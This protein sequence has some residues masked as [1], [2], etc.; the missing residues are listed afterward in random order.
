[1]IAGSVVLEAPDRP[2]P[3]AGADPL[4]PSGSPEDFD[5]LEPFEPDSP[6]ADVDPE[7][8]VALLAA[9]FPV[10]SE[11]DAGAGSGVVSAGVGGGLASSVEPA[12]ALTEVC[13][14][15]SFKGARVDA[16]APTESV[17]VARPIKIP[18][19]RKASAKAA[20]ASDEGNGSE[21]KP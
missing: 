4:A 20:Q 18:K 13:A 12:S 3:E 6:D 5:P 19:P 1:L 9:A 11:D 2:P 7:D 10:G 17:P 21:P 15:T 16:S 14:T 8:E